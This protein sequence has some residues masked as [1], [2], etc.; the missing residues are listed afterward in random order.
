VVL[1]V[2]ALDE[3]GQRAAALPLVRGLELALTIIDEVLPR[4]PGAAATDRAVLHYV[5]R[6]ALAPRTLTRDH[7]EPL[8]DAGFSARELHDIV[9]VVCCFSYMNRLA[10]GLGVTLFEE[11][12]EW[13]VR[14]YGE[15]GWRRHLAW[16]APA[17]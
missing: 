15:E 8:R 1:L 14:L 5:V 9:N 2:R 11:R 12:R 6:S 7:L 17:E 10:D 4:M 3:A 13:A 16:G